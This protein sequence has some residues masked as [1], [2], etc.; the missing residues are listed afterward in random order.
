MRTHDAPGQ[1]SG[2]L[3]QVL[4]AL[5]ILLESKDGNSQICIEKFDDVAFIDQDVPQILIQ[6]KHQI[7]KR[8]NL[9]DSSTDL[10]RTIK[11]WCDTGAKLNNNFLGTKFVI[12]TTAIADK[13]TAAFYLKGTERKTDKALEQLLNTATAQAQ[14]TNKI[15]YG[16]FL[17]LTPEQQKNL[18]G[19]IYIFDHSFHISE[20]QK[21]LKDIFKY[22]TLP[23][24]EDAV[25]ERVEGWWIKKV[26]ECLCSPETV[27]IHQKQIQA[28]V[29]EIAS[30]YRSD[31]LPIDVNFS[32]L[33][34]DTTWKNIKEPNKLFV[35]QLKLIMLSDE[36][37]KRAIR[38]Y[39]HAYQQR[40][41]WVREELLYVDELESY[42]IKLVDEWHRLFSIMKENLNDEEITEERDK[43]KYGRQLFSTIEEL[44]IHIRERV[45]QPFIMRGTFHGLANEL[46]VGWHT[47]FYQRLIELFERGI[48]C[49]TGTP[50]AQR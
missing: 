12:I 48:L 3:Y 29:F 36:R 7:S 6:T 21:Q 31:S 5:L 10:W 43:A 1:M 25:C 11:S 46:R 40:A 8:E 50:E 24:F 9:I 20:F 22:A 41:R 19:N 2:Y 32:A 28:K 37:T 16:A 30:E 15:F 18:I 35:E 49:D 34:S 23:Q 45:T 33:P 39:Y 42:E 13:N 4:A 17:S 38:D 27:L 44:D 47:E 26:I 14:S